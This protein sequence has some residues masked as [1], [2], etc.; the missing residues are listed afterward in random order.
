MKELYFNFAAATQLQFDVDKIS[1]NFED[2]KKDWCLEFLKTLVP[3]VNK[4]IKN[5]R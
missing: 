3:K 2:T 5:G 1:Q 4:R